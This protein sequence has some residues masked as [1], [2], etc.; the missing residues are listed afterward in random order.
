MEN[1]VSRTLSQKQIH[2]K[3]R[4]K[5]TT[6]FLTEIDKNHFSVKKLKNRKTFGKNKEKNWIK[7]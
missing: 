2:S 7:K 1:C 3:F 6:V 4:C 5:N